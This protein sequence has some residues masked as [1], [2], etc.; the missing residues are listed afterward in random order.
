VENGND[1]GLK[2]P[3][4]GFF[5]IVLT[6]GLGGSKFLNIPIDWRLDNF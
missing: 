5:T 1:I 4:R 6:P 2:V 3:H